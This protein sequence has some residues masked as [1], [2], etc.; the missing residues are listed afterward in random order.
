MVKNLGLGVKGQVLY[1]HSCCLVLDDVGKLPTTRCPWVKWRSYLNPSYKTLKNINW[2]ST[3]HSHSAQPIAGTQSI[4]YFNILF[5]FF[6]GAKFSCWNVLPVCCSFEYNL[7]IPWVLLKVLSIS[8]HLSSMWM[9]GWAKRPAP[10]FC[11][12]AATLWKGLGAAGA[13][14]DPQA[15]ALSKESSLEWQDV[16]LSWR[17]FALPFAHSF[18]FCWVL[19]IFFLKENKA[20]FCL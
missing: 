20:V 5:F 19:S 7:I 16:S 6:N 3:K 2:T 14:L 8:R 18:H 10:P 12:R 1:Y 9:T 13:E 17:P 4:I 11:L 15:A